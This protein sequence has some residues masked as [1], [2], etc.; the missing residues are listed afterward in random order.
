MRRYCGAAR[1]AAISCLLAI[2]FVA[3]SHGAVR[4]QSASDEAGWHSEQGDASYYG[5]AHQGRRTASGARFDQNELTAAHPW[6]PFGTRV[7]VTLESTGRSVVVT[8]TDRLKSAHRIIDLSRA[9]AAQLGF[10]RQGVA[11]VSLSPG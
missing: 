4:A 3:F 9:A 11:Y 5:K 2:V 8:V 1:T 6:L 10:I 7:R